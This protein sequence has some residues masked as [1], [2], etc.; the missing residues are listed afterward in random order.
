MKWDEILV[1]TTTFCHSYST[2]NHILCK[3][4]R[5]WYWDK[6]KITF[7]FTITSS[8]RHIC[9]FHPQTRLDLIHT[10]LDLIHT[11]LDL[12]HSRLDLIHTRLDLIHKMRSSLVVRASDCQCTSSNGPG[13]DPSIRRHRGIWGTA[14]EAELNIVRKKKKK[15]KIPP[16]KYFYSWQ[17][18]R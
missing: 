14:D 6:L 16:Q 10:R 9:D 5:W 12:I 15:K 8:T 1:C 2:G 17:L 18:F 7:E 11:R 13:F 4:V 3:S